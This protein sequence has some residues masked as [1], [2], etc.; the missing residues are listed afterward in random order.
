MHKQTQGALLPLLASFL[1][2]NAITYL[3]Q[4]IV[5]TKV[6]KPY[7]VSVPHEQ[8]TRPYQAHACQL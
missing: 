2:L 6:P 7:L 8:G 1:F 5:D 4:T 3:W